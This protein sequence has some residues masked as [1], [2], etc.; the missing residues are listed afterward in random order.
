MGYAAYDRATGKRV[1]SLYA[2][3][4]VDWFYKRE[5]HAEDYNGDGYNDL[6]M[7]VDGDFELHYLYEPEQTWPDWEEGC[8]SLNDQ[9]DVYFLV[10]LTSYPYEPQTHPDMTEA[11]KKFYD[12]MLPKIMNFEDF[13]YDVAT[14]GHETL[15]DVMGAWGY[16]M[17]DYPKINLY[18]SIVEAEDED[19]N[20][21]AYKSE[22]S[23]RWDTEPSYDIERVR[24]GLQ[25]F[26]GK[27]DDI[28]SGLQYNMSAYQ[29][30]QYLAMTISQNANY[31]Y[32]GEAG[33]PASMWGGIMGG[34]SICEGYSEAMLYLCQKANLYCEIVE[35]I[36]GNEW[37]AWNLVKTTEGTYHVDITWCDGLSPDDPETM[38]WQKYFMLNQEKILVDHEITDGTVAT[39]N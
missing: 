32:A 18:F 33:A 1:G 39:G 12:E 38:E 31:D 21:I 14:Y 3:G 34:L 7:P 8:F 2:P 27:V 4:H 28:L 9:N 24:A 13:T 25:S 16:L 10:D 5:L 15:N 30:Y 17:K 11:Q 22:Y 23:T 35:G 37:H 26:D 6:G 19:E 36:A 20:F 29:K